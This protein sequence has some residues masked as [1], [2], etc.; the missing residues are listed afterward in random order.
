MAEVRAEH[1]GIPPDH[2]DDDIR[3]ATTWEGDELVNL[4]IPPKDP[5]LFELAPPSLFE[6]AP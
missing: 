2:G 5:S 3:P 1:E 6:L 4:D